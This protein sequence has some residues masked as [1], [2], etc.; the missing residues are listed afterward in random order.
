MAILDLLP[1]LQLMSAAVTWMFNQQLKVYVMIRPVTPRPHY[2]LSFPHLSKFTSI[3]LLDE[4]K[5][6]RTSHVSSFSLSP[7]SIPDYP[8]SSCLHVCYLNAS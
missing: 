8:E 2:P 4:A 3:H 6:L 5:Y 7:I 1:E